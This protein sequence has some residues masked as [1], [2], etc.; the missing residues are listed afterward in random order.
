MGKIPMRL[1]LETLVNEER[2]CRNSKWVILQVEEAAEA[3]A[4][5]PT[6][7]I[8]DMLNP[9]S[10][11]VMLR[12]TPRRKRGRKIPSYT[13]V[14]VLKIRRT[15]K[16]ECVSSSRDFTDVTTTAFLNDRKRK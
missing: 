11:Y 12:I 7:D 13:L 1:D 3:P 10:R 8:S 14:L 16:G 6:I 5:P 15:I 9:A 4:A 2:K